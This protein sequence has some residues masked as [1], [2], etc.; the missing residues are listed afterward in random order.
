MSRVFILGT[1]QASRFLAASAKVSC[2]SRKCKKPAAN[3]QHCKTCVFSLSLSL[4]LSTYMPC[5]CIYIYKYVCK[6]IYKY[7]N[8][9]IY[10]YII[11]R[12]VLCACVCVSVCVH[13]LLEQ[14]RDILSKMIEVA[15]LSIRSHVFIDDKS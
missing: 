5:I 12:Y 10:I 6:Y 13:V 9:Y 3:M 15:T 7:I 8:I 2:E 14:T 1:S 4:S 11:Q